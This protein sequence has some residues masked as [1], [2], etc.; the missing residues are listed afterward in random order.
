MGKKVYYYIYS[1][2]G[3]DTALVEGTRFSRKEK[4]M[5]NDA[6]MERHSNVEQV[7]FVE[8]DG[9]CRLIMAGGEFCGNATRCAAFY[10]LK[11]KSG[12]IDIEVSGTE[13]LIKA[14]IDKAENVWSHIPIYTGNDAV[15]FM[16]QGIYQIKMDGITHIIVDEN[17]SGKYLEIPENIKENALKVINRFKIDET[18]AIGVMLL[19]KAN[20]GLKIHPVVWVKSID[21]TFYETACG[22]GSVAV[23]ILKSI[24]NKSG[25]SL[26]LLQ[27]SGQFIR[28][29]II[30]EKEK[31]IGA[32]ISGIVFWDGMRRTIE[33]D[34]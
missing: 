31:L 23:G 21:T 6:I 2:C 13:H 32:S 19:E 30:M 25:Q 28:T 10:Y 17:I 27:P 24:Q 12:E 7:G 11:G 15:T 16:E 22:S 29:E 33:T 26:E 3:N 1:P 14:G 8:K 4:K 34:I 9:G 5:I 18:E 20:Q